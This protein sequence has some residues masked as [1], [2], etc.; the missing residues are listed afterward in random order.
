MSELELC[1]TCKKGKESL[2]QQ[3]KLLVL[4]NWYAIIADKNGLRLVLMNMYSNSC[5]KL[6][7]NFK[8]FSKL[9]RFQIYTMFD[10]I[11][12]SSFLLE[13]R[14]YS[15]TVSVYIRKSDRNKK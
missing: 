4:E 6:F 14:M 9:N 5:F 3:K 12:L 15:N 13:N 1:P 10:I 2:E 7:Q 11:I 8:Y